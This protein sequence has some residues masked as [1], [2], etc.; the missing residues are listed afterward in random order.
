MRDVKVRRRNGWKRMILRMRDRERW[1]WCGLE[2][3]HSRTCLIRQLLR[4][5][6]VPVGGRREKVRERSGHEISLRKKKKKAM[7]EKRD[8]KYEGFG[9]RRRNR[10]R[11]RK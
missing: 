3:W 6:G 4:S 1:R 2:F 10:K 7:R 9:L 8:E 5:F 11:G